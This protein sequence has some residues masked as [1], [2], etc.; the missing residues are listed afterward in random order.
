[1]GLYAGV[2]IHW[3]QTLDGRYLLQKNTHTF[4]FQP[5][6]TISKNQTHCMKKNKNI[7][8]EY[9]LIKTIN[10]VTCHTAKEIFVYITDK[11]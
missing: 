4:H 3:N 8:S 9:N 6:C 5:P 11:R 1:M 2:M 10:T 7:S